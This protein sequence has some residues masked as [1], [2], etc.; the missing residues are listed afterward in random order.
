MS[1]QEAHAL[2]LREVARIRGEMMSV[3]KQ[4]GYRGTLQEFFQKL[5]SDELFYYKTPEHLLSAYR[6]RAKEIDPLVVKL[7]KTLPRLPYGIEP[8]KD[9]GQPGGY[10]LPECD[11]SRPGLFMLSVTTPHESPKYEMTAFLLHET[12]PGH[13]LQNALACEHGESGSPH[14]REFRQNVAFTEG[15]ALYAESLGDGL[16]LY[17]DPYDRFGRLVM[18]MLRAV[19]L[20]I[21]TG[22]HAYHWD[23]Q[24]VLDYIIQNTGHPTST[25]QAE[26]DRAIASPGTLLG[27][28]IGEMKIRSL[29]TRAE[30]GLRNSFDI[31]EFHDA[32]LLPGPLPLEV[33][34]NSI[35]R[36]I[37][38]RN[39]AS[40]NP[41]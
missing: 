33:L 3:V 27:Y 41:N 19:R 15:W 6:A 24:K 11:G 29:R 1:A 32:V 18:D 37:R 10:R 31:K 8:I 16:S 40:R 13:H 2:G 39:M 36:W 34:E 5:R 14:R 23:R 22:I 20:V 12:V 28:K 38:Q 26:F 7:F 21:D 17:S 30:Q 35:D 9:P 25:A 4:V